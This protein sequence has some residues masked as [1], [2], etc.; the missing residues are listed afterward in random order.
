VNTVACFVLALPCALALLWLAQ[1]GTVEPVCR[2]HGAA[3]GLVF[4]GV[5][6]YSR[7]ESTTVCVYTQATGES[8]EVS[9]QK[10][11]PF[12]TDLWVGFALDLKFTLPAFTVLFALFR[13]FVFAGTKG[14]QAGT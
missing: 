11:A 2:A 4:A 13:T 14:R 1:R 10:L 5:K 6:H 9:F 3:Q 12:V 7:D 8:S